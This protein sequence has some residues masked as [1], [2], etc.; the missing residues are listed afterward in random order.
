MNRPTEELIEK[1]ESE[2]QR[3]KQNFEDFIFYSHLRDYEEVEYNNQYNEVNGS[4]SDL[5]EIFKKQFICI[6]LQI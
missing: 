4:L 2:K 1:L 6:I 3:L 5:I